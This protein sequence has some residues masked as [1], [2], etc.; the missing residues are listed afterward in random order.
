MINPILEIARC[1]E[2]CLQ[3][4]KFNRNKRIGTCERKGI[5][6]PFTIS[7]YTVCRFWYP[8]KS[9]ERAIREEI[10]IE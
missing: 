2:T 7:R 4:H 9:Q 10:E 6:R 8:D 3:N 1:C 5:L